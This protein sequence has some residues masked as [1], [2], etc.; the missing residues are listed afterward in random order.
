MGGTRTPMSQDSLWFSPKINCRLQNSGARL[1]FYTEFALGLPATGCG[2]DLHME[3]DGLPRILHT[4]PKAGF[5][6]S[7]SVTSEF[8][9]PKHP[10]QAIILVSVE[11]KDVYKKKSDRNSPFSFSSRPKAGSK[12]CFLSFSS[13][14]R[15]AP[16]Y[17]KHLLTIT[18]QVIELD[19][20]AIYKFAARV[21]GYGCCSH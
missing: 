17:C 5:A 18:R 12:A 3:S 9:A 1:S 20:A 21:G 4:S 16:D 15:N 7:R 14:P 13:Y 2:I 8:F 19:M 10:R 11:A 6:I